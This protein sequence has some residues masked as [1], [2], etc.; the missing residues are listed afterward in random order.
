MTI[1][2]AS[3]NCI[4][5]CACMCVG[6]CVGVSEEGDIVGWSFRYFLRCNFLAEW[7]PGPHC[8]KACEPLV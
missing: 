7:L 5:V 4:C 3:C 1:M 8:G 6:V 2:I